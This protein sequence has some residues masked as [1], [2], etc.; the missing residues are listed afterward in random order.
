MSRRTWHFG[1]LSVES[2]PRVIARCRYQVSRCRRCQSFQSCNLNR[3]C[4]AVRVNVTWLWK[5]RK[6]LTSTKFWSRCARTGNWT[7]K[8]TRK[9]KQTKRQWKERTWPQ[10]NSHQRRRRWKTLRARWRLA[11]NCTEHR[12][13]TTEAPC[14]RDKIN[15]PS[16]T[17]DLR[18]SPRPSSVASSLTPGWTLQRRRTECIVRMTA[19]LH[20]VNWAAVIWTGCKR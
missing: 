5:T 19:E 14:P 10:N 11:T 1:T 12:A 20:W 9:S 3:C 17:Q 6:E 18:L 16:T 7:R 8:S 4:C 15:Q 2:C 13:W